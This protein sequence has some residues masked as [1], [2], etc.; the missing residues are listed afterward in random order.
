MPQPQVMAPEVISTSGSCSEA[1][2]QGKVSQFSKELKMLRLTGLEIHFVL[3][4]N[5]L[6]VDL[7]VFHLDKGCILLN[8]VLR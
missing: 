5:G 8:L 3:F 6:N 2:K 4:F 1:E 7:A